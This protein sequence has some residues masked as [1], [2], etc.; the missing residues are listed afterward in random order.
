MSLSRLATRALGALSARPSLVA[1]ASRS[2]HLR[3]TP[4]SSRLLPVR[5]LAT[6]A[7]GDMVQFLTE[8]IKA[9]KDNQRQLPKVDGFKVEAEGAD[10]T[11]TKE[12]G[13]EK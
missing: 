9:E 2:C 8:E 3:P 10:L 6:K 7:D 4:S 11:F 5:C 13:A 1:A 12:F